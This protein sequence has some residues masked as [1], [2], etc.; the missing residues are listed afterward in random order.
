MSTR[1]MYTFKDESGEFHVYKHHDGYPSG[2][3]GHIK[4]AA[5][6]AWEPPRFE[7]DEF[8]AAFVAANKDG[9]GGVRLMNTG[10]WKKVAPGDLEFRYEITAP[11]KAR[12]ENPELACGPVMVAAFEV[13]CSYPANKW[14][15]KRIFSGTLTEF[16]A[17]ANK[18]VPAQ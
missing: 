17:G 16:E 5:G 10:P 15:E 1:A 7:A 2:A 4:A 12:V 9:P 6:N 3:A 18:P 13:H 8:G 14:T 11:A